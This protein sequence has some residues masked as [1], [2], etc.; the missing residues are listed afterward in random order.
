MYTKIHEHFSRSFSFQIA[1]PITFGDAVNSYQGD[2]MQQIVL[3]TETTGLDPKQG[4]RIIEIAAVK[5]IDRQLTQE[6]FHH[7]INPERNIDHGAQQV[8]GITTHFLKD[9][10]LF[11]TIFQSFLDFI[12]GAELIIHNAPFDIGFIN[13][14]FGHVGYLEKTLLDHCRVTDTLRLAKQLHPGQRNNLDALCARY[15]IDKSQRKLH[16]AL[17]DATLLAHVYL[18]MTGGQAKLFEDENVS[19][20]RAVIKNSKK[21]KKTEKIDLPV[22]LATPEELQLHQ[23]QLRSIKEKSKKCMWEIEEK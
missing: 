11:R 15:S 19:A 20:N 6:H 10:P 21:P 5:L 22:I 7:Y 12:D 9:K 3:D 18:R 1:H 17:L 13:S 14:E 4:H 2:N 16:G 23:E 8:H